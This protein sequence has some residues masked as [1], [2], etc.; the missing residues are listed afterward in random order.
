M[1][2]QPDGPNSKKASP[3]FSVDQC[4]PTNW[5][6]EYTKYNLYRWS[7]KQNYI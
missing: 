3:T 5:W 1:G 4:Y 2:Q 7:W 6:K